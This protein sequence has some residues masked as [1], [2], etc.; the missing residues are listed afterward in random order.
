MLKLNNITVVLIDTLDDF[1]DKSNIRIA[2]MSR[3]LPKILENVEFGEVLI[4]NPFN[5]NKSLIDFNQNQIVWNRPDSKVTGVNWYSEFVVS[6]LPY[7]IKT[8]YYLIIQWDGFFVNHFNWNDIFLNYDYIGGGHT[9]LNGGF[10]LRKT[11]TMIKILE[12]G[13]PQS[14]TSIGINNEDQLYSS[15]LN[16]PKKHKNISNPK[17]PF[18]IKMPKENIVNKFCS[19]NHD[20]NN[21]FGWHRN[22]NLSTSFCI[23]QYNRLNIFSIQEMANIKNYLLIKETN[24]IEYNIKDFSIEYNDKFFI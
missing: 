23:K 14:L 19:F 17:L 24:N 3:I 9:I 7:L 22:G 20:N 5:K 12:K 18:Y 15:Y 2:I 1:C 4:I 21:S 11:E 8:D 6:K 16:L 10:S 13:N